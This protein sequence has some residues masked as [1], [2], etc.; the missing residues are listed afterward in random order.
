[1]V[2]GYCC[3]GREHLLGFSHANLSFS[4]GFVGCELRF[5]GFLSYFFFHSFISFSFRFLLL[6]SADEGYKYSWGERANLYGW[7]D[8]RGFWRGN[9]CNLGSNSFFGSDP[10]PR[11]VQYSITG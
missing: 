4:L 11:P 7:R 9:S 8:H 5:P 6:F 3:I 10:L 1:M 2:F